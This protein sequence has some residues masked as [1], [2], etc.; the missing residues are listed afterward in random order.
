MNEITEMWQKKSSEKP[1]VAPSLGSLRL[2]IP[3][4]QKT[5]HVRLSRG[6][7]SRRSIDHDHGKSCCPPER[8]SWS[9]E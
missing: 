9:T 3:L 6:G 1:D 2:I 7:Q 5:R 8:V 4:A